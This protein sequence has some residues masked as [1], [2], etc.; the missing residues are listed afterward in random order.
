M[1]YLAEVSETVLDQRVASLLLV[2][3]A[4]CNHYIIKIIHQI[5]LKTPYHRNKYIYTKIPNA[6]TSLLLYVLKKRDIIVI[7]VILESRENSGLHCERPDNG[8]TDL[9]PHTLLLKK[10]N[11]RQKLVLQVL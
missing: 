9:D 6:I 7:S 2:I 4:R 10:I 8:F 11:K 5:T 1:D 3:P